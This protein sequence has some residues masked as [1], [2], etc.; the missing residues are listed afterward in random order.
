MQDYSFISLQSQLYPISGTGSFTVSLTPNL[1]IQ[2]NGILIGY[3][4]GSYTINSS[5]YNNLSFIPFL[6]QLNQT[7]SFT[8]NSVNSFTGLAIILF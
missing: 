4:T 2:H 3:S 8:I 5:S 7:Y 1:A 6:A